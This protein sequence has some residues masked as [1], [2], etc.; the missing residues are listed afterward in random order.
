M[1]SFETAKNVRF[2]VPGSLGFI[3]SM[4]TLGILDYDSLDFT[5]GNCGE[6]NNYENFRSDEVIAHCRYCGRRNKVR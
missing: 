4:F 2:W 6:H 3:A 1:L 5:C